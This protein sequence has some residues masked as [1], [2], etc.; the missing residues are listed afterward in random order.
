[1]IDKCY[2]GM[3]TIPQR[4]NDP[5]GGNPISTNCVQSPTANP[6]LSL[7]S[8]ATQTQINAALSSALIYKDSQIATISNQPPLQLKTVGGIGLVGT[9]DIP[10]PSGGGGIIE[11]TYAEL[12]SLIASSTL[13]V[14]QVYLL[15]DYMTTYTQPVTNT[16][17]SSGVVEQLFLTAVDINKLHKIAKSKLYP[18]DIIYYEVT[19]DIETTIYY[20]GNLIEF[21]TEG[22]TKGKIYR[23]IDTL[24]N[25]DV[26]T[27]WRHIKYWNPNTSTNDLLFKKYDGFFFPAHGHFNIKIETYH[28]MDSIFTDVVYNFNVADGFYHNILGDVRDSNIGSRFQNNTIG[29]IGSSN[30]KNEFINNEISMI[31]GSVIEDVFTDNSILQILN[32]S[33]GNN[34]YNNSG[35][36]LGH[37]IIHDNFRINTFDN[38]AYCTLKDTFTNNNLG[39]GFI[40]NKIEYNFSNNTVGTA[41]SD[42][43]ISIG[44]KNNTVGYDF[45]YN[46][47]GRGFETNTIDYGFQYN[48]IGDWF[49]SN[50]IGSNFYSNKIEDEFASNN[51]PDNIAYNRYTVSELPNGLY[52]NQRFIVTNALNPTYLSVVVGGGTTL[53]SVM[54]NNVN[55]TWIVS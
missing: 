40:Y 26:G 41:F 21:D 35:T 53:T 4:I 27:D 16:A 54:W 28:L 1:M 7:P 10:L 29:S 8:G 36:S 50:T 42:N 48:I 2:E 22:F 31:Q 46:N 14:G 24:R 39:F 45:Q 38:I 52:Q 23:R 30:L 43:N 25:V 49:F 32:S 51:L 34:C 17:M 19:G 18:Q 12:T 13:V 44:F 15:T 20:D 55:N 6:Y 9:G 5:C 11:V 47:I 37:S 33:I 3:T